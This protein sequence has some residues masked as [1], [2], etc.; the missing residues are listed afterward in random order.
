MKKSTS[1][2]TQIVFRMPYHPDEEASWRW[3]IRKVFRST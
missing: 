2:V 3:R 1:L